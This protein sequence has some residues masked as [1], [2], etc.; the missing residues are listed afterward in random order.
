[1]ADSIARDY[2]S[3]ASITI[4]DAQIT[5]DI[6]NFV[7][8]VTEHV[9][10]DEFL[11]ADGTYAPLSDGADVRFFDSNTN[12]LTPL[13]FDIVNF[14][15]D[16][17]PANSKVEIHVNVPL[18]KKTGTGDTVIHV[19]WGMP[20]ETALADDH[21]Y[22]RDNAYASRYKG[23]Y[24]MESTGTNLPDR[25][26]NSNDGTKQ[27]SGDPAH[28]ATSGQYF[29]GQ[30]FSGDGSSYIDLVDFDLGGVFYVQFAMKTDVTNPSTAETI[31]S[32][33]SGYGASDKGFAVT[34]VAG[35]DTQLHVYGDAGSGAAF[36]AVSSIGD[37]NWHIYGFHFLNTTCEI[38][39]DGNWKTNVGITTV[40]NNDNVICLGDGPDHDEPDFDGFLDDV[41]IMS[42]CAETERYAL[43]RNQ[44]NPATFASKGTRTAVSDPSATVVIDNIQRGSFTMSGTSQGQAVTAVDLSK[45]ILFT[46]VRVSGADAPGA[47]DFHCDIYMSST[48]NIQA[49]RYGSSGTI[50][51][52]YQ[53][54]E[55]SAGVTVER[56]NNQAMG[57]A[58]TDE[59]ETMS[60]PFNRYRSFIMMNY[61]IN[62]TAMDSDGRLSVEFEHSN[63]CLIKRATSGSVAGT[64]SIQ[65]VQYDESEVQWL[66]DTNSD[67]ATS[68]TD[69]TAGS[70]IVAKTFLVGTLR[71]SGSNTNDGDQIVNME[72][73]DVDTVTFRKYS[74]TAHGIYYRVFV[75][76]FTDDTEVQQYLNTL[77]TG[78]TEVQAVS[79][80]V[81]LDASVIVH[82]GLEPSLV[83]SEDTLEDGDEFA[84]TADLTASNSMSMIRGN[85][86]SIE[87]KLSMAVINF[88]PVSGLLTNL[89]G[90]FNRGFLGGFQ[91]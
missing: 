68:F 5:Q 83:S 49:T 35:S 73:T 11:D 32:N 51:I 6:S 39:I 18:V 36:T 31:I 57:A 75:V 3:Y 67:A 86:S 74:A 58:I 45:S 9:L 53:L 1:M 50:T 41:F 2:E 88:N 12:F 52:E 91:T 84:F 82:Q 44:G 71:D 28:S 40:Q 7:F 16:N 56:F 70:F 17:T 14:D 23:V 34:R 54:V 42:S 63:N 59:E 60:N 87:A 81:N 26:S 19:V 55:F 10:P 76:E 77:E 21:T 62:Q 48:T 65:V 78:D 13:A 61:A 4:D 46:S 33:K 20:R 22:G 43:Q 24:C 80:A 8:K 27:S 79:P 30:E 69:D 66:N 90:N 25:T 47:D 37:G 38:Y 89:K 85:S 29:D 64:Y 72:L 15:L